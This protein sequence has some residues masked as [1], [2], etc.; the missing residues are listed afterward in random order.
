MQGNQVTKSEQDATSDHHNLHYI[1]STAS[2]HTFNAQPC[3][4]FL[5]RLSRS[6]IAELNPSSLYS[7]YPLSF[8][9]L[10]IPPSA[11]PRPPPEGELDKAEGLVS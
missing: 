2:P 7:S 6:R 1:S 5:H 3:F 9:P 11:A 10:S 8:S 4:L